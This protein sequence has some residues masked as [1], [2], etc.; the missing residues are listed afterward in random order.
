MSGKNGAPQR[1]FLILFWVFRII[2]MVYWAPKPY[3]NYKG[4]CIRASFVKRFFLAA[5][6]RFAGQGFSFLPPDAKTSIETQ[7]YCCS[8]GVNR[9]LHTFKD[10][11]QAIGR[12]GSW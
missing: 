12:S 4:P 9:P 10:L 6:A 7:S 11:T 5:N 1:P 3:A 8:L 2:I